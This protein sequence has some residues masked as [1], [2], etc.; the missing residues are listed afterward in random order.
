VV[1]SI[2]RA[3]A[4]TE[5]SVPATS[6]RNNVLYA[7]VLGMIQTTSAFVLNNNIGASC[8]VD[9]ATY[10]SFSAYQE[11]VQLRADQGQ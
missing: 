2:N 5:G 9:G 11:G 8:Q 1:D 3:L 4:P 10:T 6:F 7:T